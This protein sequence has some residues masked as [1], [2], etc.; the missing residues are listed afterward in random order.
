MV[1]DAAEDTGRSVTDLAKAVLERRG[2]AATADRA[3]VPAQ[4]LGAMDDGT[5]REGK[6]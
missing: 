2:E 5:A 6:I 4:A 3:R 1:G